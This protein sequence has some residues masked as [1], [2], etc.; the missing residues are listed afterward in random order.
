MRH[1]MHNLEEPMPGTLT[2]ILGGARSGKSSYELQLAHHV[3]DVLFVATAERRDGEMAAKIDRH[4][5]ERPPDWHTLEEPLKL[6][7]AL[8]QTPL[9]SVTSIDCV[10]LWVSNRLLADDASWEV[11]VTELDTLIAWHRAAATDLIIVSNEVGLGIV[12]EHALSRTYREWLGWF[13]RR[14]ATEADQVFFM[15]AGLPIEVKSLA[16]GSMTLG[17]PS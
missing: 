14:L 1:R 17:F 13:N 11:A 6:A 9:A 15:V 12:P 16:A 7:V 2:L 8:A 5:S 3:P 10:T 4:R